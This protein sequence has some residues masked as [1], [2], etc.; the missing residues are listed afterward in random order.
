M[1]T[2]ASPQAPAA[3]PS[4]EP[5][6]ARVRDL[7]PP[8]STTAELDK[9][10]A[11]LEAHRRAWVDLELADRRAILQEVMKDFAG[12]AERWYERGRDA[13]GLPTDMPQAAEEWLSGPYMVLRNL[14]LLDRALGE[15]ARSGAP[16]IP[17]PVTERPDGTTVAQVFPTD[18]WDQLFYAGVTGEVWMQP[19]VTP[20]TLKETM[21]VAYQGG[22]DAD[23]GCCLVLGAGN[24]S[25]I[26]PM[27]VLYKLFVEHKT[28]LL[29]MHPVNAYLGPLITEGF[30]ALVDWGVLRVVYGGV[31]VGQYLCEHPDI[32]EI[33]ITGSDK[34][35][36]AIVFGPGPEG[37]ER[38]RKRRPRN[39]TPI[40]SELGNVSPVIVVPGPW[41]AGDLAFQGENIASMLTNNA[42]FNCNAA[43]VV[44]QHSGW[45]KRAPLLDQVRRVLRSTPTRYAYYPGAAERWAAF[46]DAHPEAEQLGRPRD[47]DLPWTLIPD[48]DPSHRDDICFRE[49]AFCSVLAET[50]LDA[51]DPAEFLDRAVELCNNTLWGTLNAAILVHPKSLA[52]PK[53]RAAFERAL[54]NLHYGTIGVNAWPAVGY[55]LV[56][57]PWGAPPGH[58]IYDI[59]SGTGEVHNTLMFSRIQKAVVRVP[60]RMRPKPLWFASHRTALAMAERVTRFEVEP[61]LTKLPGIFWE[62]LRG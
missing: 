41:S 16:K 7:I 28:T 32:T 60:F 19:G 57:T 5:S 12:V 17:G 48:V 22:A 61:A 54:E 20:S 21:A 43:R 18:G 6:P 56:V 55:G 15:I 23:G 53:L 24:V 33:H 31:D 51:A 34:T 8:D 30:Q 37:Q 50:G 45:K 9:A 39:K 11:D 29:K 38:K 40:S 10:L 42:G 26:G 62:A 49:E 35:V 52:Q 44:I 36:D 2:Q 46:V 47:S 4:I 14:T 3:I 13:E 59:Q 1:M 58:D 25:S 27:D